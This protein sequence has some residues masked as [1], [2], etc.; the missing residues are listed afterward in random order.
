MV[1]LRIRRSLADITCRGKKLFK[2]ELDEVRSFESLRRNMC[3]VRFCVP[4][5]NFGAVVSGL[6]GGETCKTLVVEDSEFSGCAAA[7]PG[8]KGGAI[9]MFNTPAEIS[10]TVISGSTGTAMV[11]ESS[12]PDGDHV[13]KVS[14]SLVSAGTTI[15]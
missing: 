1:F 15:F 14:H 2:C 12:S 9:A 4:Q 10:G 7:L 13:L 3:Y 5:A 8:G 11:F 6:P